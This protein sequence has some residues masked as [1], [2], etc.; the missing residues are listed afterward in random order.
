MGNKAATIGAVLVAGGLLAAPAVMPLPDWAGQLRDYPVE[1][2]E[3]IAPDARTAELNHFIETQRSLKDAWNDPKSRLRVDPRERGIKSPGPY[4]VI[5]DRVKDGDTIEVTYA[6]GYCGWLPCRGSKSD[7]RIWGIDSG[8]TR[9]GS[10]QSNADC[11]GERTAGE[12]AKAFAKHE[13]VEGEPLVY[14]YNLRADPYANRWVATIAYQEDRKA[15][16]KF[17]HIEALQLVTPD[18]KNVFAHYNPIANQVL[19][20]GGKSGF[21]KRKIWCGDAGG[22]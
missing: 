21:D 2:V 3:A 1:T 22:E 20:R 6:S 15:P 16:F 4:R 18:G 13:L 7:I 12:A 8:E 11:G 19:K 9:S 14:A 17:F 5:V 10:G